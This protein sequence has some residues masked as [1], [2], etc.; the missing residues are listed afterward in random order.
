MGRTGHG[1]VAR[2][3]PCQSVTPL[4]SVP[5]TREVQAGKQASRVRH[6]HAWVETGGAGVT[7]DAKRTEAASG[8]VS[9]G[10]GAS[11]DSSTSTACKPE[12]EGADDDD[13]KEDEMTEER[14]GMF[15]STADL[16]R[17]AQLC[18][19]MALKDGPE[20]ERPIRI[21][22]ASRHSIVL[23]TEC[24]EAEK[25]AVA[26]SATYAWTSTSPM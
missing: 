16:N 26:R 4:T 25:Q 1:G 19:K 6:T 14:E 7:I 15:S 10:G 8:D 21:C 5:I 9:T 3:G 18:S 12:K 23:R 17:R 20:V 2:R 13:D 22:E 11:P 24:L